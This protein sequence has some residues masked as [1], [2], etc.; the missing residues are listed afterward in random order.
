M[1]KPRTPFVYP[2]FTQEL[3]GK[4]FPTGAKE[5]HGCRGDVLDRE[6]GA[7]QDGS[8]Q[9]ALAVLTLAFAR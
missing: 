4:F 5:T 6:P 7:A 3:P 8:G 9:R 2:D 1:Q